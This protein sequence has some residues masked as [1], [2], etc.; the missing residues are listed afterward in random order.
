MSRRRTI[1]QLDTDSDLVSWPNRGGRAGTQTR[2]LCDA[3]QR[4]GQQSRRPERNPGGL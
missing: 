1:T 2:I 4:S 3:I